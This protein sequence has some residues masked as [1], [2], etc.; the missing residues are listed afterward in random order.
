MLEKVWAIE[1][2]EAKKEPNNHSF[3]NYTYDV[4]L[5]NSSF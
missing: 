1:K 2:S 3:Q 4:S 5:K